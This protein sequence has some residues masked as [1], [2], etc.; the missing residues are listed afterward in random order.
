MTVSEER[1]E[2]LRQ[3]YIWL[4]DHPNNS[5]MPGR[6]KSDAEHVE[7]IEELQRRRKGRVE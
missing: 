5:S 3:N 2:K 4:R 7:I 1:L 6:E